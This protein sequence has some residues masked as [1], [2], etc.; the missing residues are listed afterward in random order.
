MGQDSPASPS[1]YT[2]T[3][4]TLLANSPS[5]SHTPLQAQINEVPYSLSIQKSQ[6]QLVPPANVVGAAIAA[7]LLFKTKNGDKDNS[8]KVD[9]KQEVG[10]DLA[11]H[12][13]R[14]DLDKKI[15]RAA[16]LVK[17]E[18]QK[19]RKR[20]QT[21]E[22]ELSRLRRDGRLWLLG[23]QG[24]AE[25]NKPPLHPL[26]LQALKMDSSHH[27]DIPGPILRLSAIMA[28]TGQLASSSL[29]SLV[30]SSTTFP[31]PFF[32]SQRPSYQTSGESTSV[33]EAGMLFLSSFS[34]TQL[35]LRELQHELQQSLCRNRLGLSLP[36]LFGSTATF[37]FTKKQTPLNS[38]EYQQMNQ[39]TG[40]QFNLDA[41]EQ[42]QQILLAPLIQQSKAP[43]GT[44]SIPA[45][46][47]RYL[48][49]TI[50]SG[51]GSGFNSLRKRK[52]NTLKSQTESITTHSLSP[53][54]TTLSSTSSPVQDQ[55]LQA[56]QYSTLTEN[57]NLNNPPT[58]QNRLTALNQTLSNINKSHT[59]SKVFSSPDVQT[60][61][62]QETSS[63]SNSETSSSSSETVS[64]S[65]SSCVMI[66]GMQL[67]NLRNNANSRIAPVLTVDVLQYGPLCQMETRTVQELDEALRERYPILDSLDNT[68]PDIE[69]EMNNLLE[70]DR[71]EE[72]ARLQRS[73][74]EAQVVLTALLR[75]GACSIP[76]AQHRI[77]SEI[78][79][80]RHRQEA[81]DRQ[82]SEHIAEQLSIQKYEIGKESISVEEQNHITNQAHENRSPS[83]P[84]SPIQMPP[85]LLS[86]PDQQNQIS[87][88]CDIGSQNQFGSGQSPDSSST[89]LSSSDL[90]SQE[91]ILKE[92]KDAEKA[93]EIQKQKELLEKRVQEIA[94]KEQQWKQNLTEQREKINQA[95]NELNAISKR[96]KESVAKL[97]QEFGDEWIVELGERL[98]EA[99]Q[100]INSEIRA[101]QRE[102][103]EKAR[104]RQSGNGRLTPELDQ[105]SEQ[106]RMARQFG[107]T[108]LLSTPQTQPSN[109]GDIVDTPFTQKS[110]ASSSDSSEQTLSPQSLN[111]SQPTTP[112]D[113]RNS[114]VPMT[115][116]SALSNRSGDETK[117]PPSTSTEHQRGEQ[118][119][120]ELRSPMDPI[121][122]SGSE[123][124]RKSR[125]NIDI[126]IPQQIQPEQDETIVDEENVENENTNEDTGEFELLNGNYEEES[127]TPVG[128][129]EEI[130]Q[131]DEE[132]EIGSLQRQGD[133]ALYLP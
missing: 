76:S 113:D 25:G 94:L 121:S 111:A 87:N 118:L 59:T 84:T 91:R 72:E 4:A 22:N 20:E 31:F 83:P 39:T 9:Y 36:A 107:K 127:R 47:P 90:T 6:H 125:E 78:S 56:D 89:D 110:S 48:P 11:Q 51:L 98:Y 116:L 21:D 54:L 61:I 101:K 102:L 92:Q 15:E 82:E 34:H 29:I 103:K 104:L 28:L 105:D 109:L 85:L 8:L 88:I 33:V 42:S 5:P 96:L 50:Q 27:G 49:P 123:I 122:D 108:L 3:P 38:P 1:I 128:G 24:L 93:A 45:P 62:N 63:E 99:R 10:D 53:S 71:T 14:L 58:D 97:L 68:I 75:M 131:L 2:Q 100:D 114:L 16:R 12:L 55:S 19:Q 13:K 60:T 17:R 81:L 86:S 30:T 66:G 73:R 70:K 46:Q 106:Q 44:G 37:Q 43:Q 41:N 124:E 126:D 26:L 57:Q 74:N 32:N 40:S 112:Q 120:N 95:T 130:L 69:K 119:E 115:P 35:Q 132:E 65:S 117:T 64:S 133:L 18:K 67:C 77:Q 23:M 129:Q 80:L 52:S 79:K 7:I